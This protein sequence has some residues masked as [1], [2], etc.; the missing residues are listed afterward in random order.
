M[1]QICIPIELPMNIPYQS[2][3]IQHVNTLMSYCA[4]YE[5][6]I[7]MHTTHAVFQVKITM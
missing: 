1:K 4:E 6:G 2:N 5:F 3:D 7:L